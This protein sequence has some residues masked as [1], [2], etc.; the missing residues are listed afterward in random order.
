MASERATADDDRIA[1]R[2]AKAIELRARNKTIREIAAELE[3]SVGQ[4]HADVQAAKLAYAREAED[5]VIAERGLELRRLERALEVVE[6]VLDGT[7]PD[8]EELR[9][10]ALDR[11]VKIQDQRAKLLGL[12]A[13][14]RKEIDAK[15]ASVGLDELDAMRAAVSANECGPS[16]ETTEKSEPSS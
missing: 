8:G 15:V 2:Q 9:L 1:L 16:S 7:D 4:A 6:S 5:N 13:P 11:L 10:K 12:Y 14:E 3:I